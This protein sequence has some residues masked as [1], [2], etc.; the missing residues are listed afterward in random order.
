MKRIL[1]HQ[2]RIIADK[3]IQKCKLLLKPLNIFININEIQSRSRKAELV[4]KRA[5]VVYI[6]NLKK[7]KSVYIA[8]VINRDHSNVL[9][10]IKFFNKKKKYKKLLKTIEALSYKKNIDF[11]INF[12]KKE[13]KK[14]QQIKRI[15]YFNL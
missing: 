15:K 3:E 10:L 4:I 12:H 8:S 6:L 7:F 9:Y 13:I 2:D 11:Q 1:N 14:L 5:L